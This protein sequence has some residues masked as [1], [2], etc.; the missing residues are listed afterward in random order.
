ME[1]IVESCV[2][3]SPEE[4]REKIRAAAFNFTEEV[5]AI[6]GEAFAAV[7]AEFQSGAGATRSVPV[8][9]T[10]TRSKPAKS[11]PAI[12]SKTAVANKPKKVAGKRNRRTLN[13]LD[14]V[15]N[16]VIKL[17]SSQNRSMRIEEI[18]SELGTSTRQLMRP[19]QR[20]LNQG[21]IKKL[22]ERRATSYHI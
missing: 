13:E 18:N 20:L 21:K 6:F 16:E 11:K 8:K 12:R 19:I 15:G 10:V 22:G 3:M 4:V 2:A 9:A 14:R 1:S 5:S 17:L 7:A